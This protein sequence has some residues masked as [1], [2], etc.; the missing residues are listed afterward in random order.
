MEEILVC[1]S[2]APSNVRVIKA[3]A[4][5]AEAYGGNMTALY[6]EPPDL[7]EHE[8]E[9]LARLEANFRLAHRLGA[10]VT[11]LYGEDAATQIAEYARVSGSTKIVIGKSPTRTSVFRKKTLIDRLNELAPDVDIFIIP[12]KTTPSERARSLSFSDEKFSVADVLKTLGLLT[13]ATLG[14]LG[15]TKLGFSTANVIILYIL[16]VLGI[17]VTTAG[18]SYSLAS[19]VLSVFVFNF[20]FTVP[21]YSLSAEPSE[22]AT[23][24]VMFIAA[25]IISSLTTQIKRQARLKAQHS[26]RTEILLETSQRM[27]K[28]ENEEQI[29]S[30]AATQLGKL[31]GSGIMIF[32]VTNGTLGEPMLFPVTEGEDFSAYL[33]PSELAA[34][35][36]ALA[37]AHGT[38]C[39]T[40]RCSD[41]KGLYMAMRS[42]DEVL[43]V[44]CF[45]V[46]G[47]PERESYSRSLTVAI[48][49]ECGIML[50]NER[51]KLAKREM[52]EKA[53]TQELRANLL[54]SISHDLRTPLTG[55]SGS[56]S[57]LLTGKMSEDKRTELLKAIR[58]DSEW[59]ITLVENL[60]CITRIEGRDKLT[61]LEPELVGEV[62]ADALT[63]IDRSSV[64][65]NVTTDIADDYLM[66]NM[67][68][69]LIEQVL[70]N[71][72]N[73]AV[74]YTPTGSTIC[75]SAESSDGRVLVS[76]SDNG[77][78]IADASKGK[79][80]DM[81][82]TEAKTG[83]S[84]RG[85]GLGL[86]L[87]KN[88]VTAHGGEITVSDAEPHGA[89]FTFSLPEV[90]TDEQGSDTGR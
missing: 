10:K 21:R 22:I 42:G 9:A 78:G 41:A 72:V 26:Y 59:L 37:T 14:G 90:I 80:F 63:H 77:P 6:V 36:Q 25:I 58:D 32:P 55:I 64:N 79:I 11:R 34:A 16:A 47:K 62:I 38:G 1:L 40:Q 51:Y 50:E 30:L 88:I 28:A 27:Q 23:F 17:A 53:R 18:R 15:F 46:N 13:A 67:D 45:A 85:L 73:N 4:K 57:L 12:D 60:L 82:Y 56:A 33:A 71:L 19:A 39:G 35:R 31:S 20:L 43:A 65:H 61:E 54:R 48:L 69:R 3:A 7:Q 76:V 75:V 81:F 83:D 8:P 84:R 74:K 52:E 5:M 49:D 66:A 87:C 89:V 2:G 70:I 44:V 86:A 24:V 68:A 29:L